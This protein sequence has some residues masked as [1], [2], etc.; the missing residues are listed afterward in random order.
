MEK[1]K[2]EHTE[3]QRCGQWIVWECVCSSYASLLEASAL[4]SLTMSVRV[5]GYESAYVCVYAVV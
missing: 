5:C 4:F 2:Q 1:N 3:V